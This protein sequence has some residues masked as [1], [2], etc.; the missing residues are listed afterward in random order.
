MP[1]KIR[2]ILTKAYGKV[3]AGLPDFP[4]KVGN[5]RIA[6][7]IFT[8]AR[9]GCSICFPH[10]QDTNNY[11][12]GKNRKSWKFYRKKQYRNRDVFDG[13]QEAG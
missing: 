10:G 7:M 8:G 4:P 6:R 9:G 11:S 12:G 13:L 2:K 1:M 5:T 3:D